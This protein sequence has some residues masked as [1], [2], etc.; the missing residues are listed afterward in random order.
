MKH[1]DLE[2][3]LFELDGE[4]NKLEPNLLIQTM[5]TQGK[6]MFVEVTAIDENAKTISINTTIDSTDATNIVHLQFHEFL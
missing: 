3:K 6:P 4:K 2:K 5:D 1:E